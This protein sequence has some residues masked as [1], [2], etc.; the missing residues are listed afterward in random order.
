MIDKPIT[1]QFKKP[2]QPTCDEVQANLNNYWMRPNE[3]AVVSR[4]AIEA[5]I[6]QCSHCQDIFV[7]LTENK[8]PPWWPT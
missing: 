2:F 4:A 3:L 7:E 5:H 1:L 6:K 8:Q